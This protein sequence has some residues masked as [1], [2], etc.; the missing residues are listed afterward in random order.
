MSKSLGNFTTVKDVLDK[1][2][3]GEVIRFALLSTHYRS[4]LDWNDKLLHDAKVTLDK[5]YR[6]VENTD[7]LNCLSDDL[8]IAKAIS[9]MHEAKPK[10]LLAMANLLGFLQQ[11]PEEWFK[12]DG[13]DSQIQT[14]INDRIEAKKAKNWSVADGIRKKLADDGIILE[15]KPDGTTDWRRT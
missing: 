9:I 8:N 10:E 15:D 3:R 2:V 12:G 14:L 6:L 5:W 11:S 1:G 7:F 4:P 13:D